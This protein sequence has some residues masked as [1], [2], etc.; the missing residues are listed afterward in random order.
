MKEGLLN[1]MR[2]SGVFASCR[3]THRRQAMILTYHRFGDQDHG[4]QISARA[5]E[6][7]LEYL[8]AHYSL[9][10][11]S[12]MAV[13]LAG[14][15]PLPSR[16]AAITIDDGYHDAYDIA[17]PLL[18]KYR[19]PA[20]VFVVSDFVEGQIWLWTD[21][22]RYFTARAARRQQAVAIE[23]RFLELDLSSAARREAAAEKINAVLKTLPEKARDAALH[24]LARELDVFL[25]E[26][27]PAEFSSICWKQARAMAAGGVEIGSHTVTHPI[28]TGLTDERLRRE[29]RHSKAHIEAELGRKVE[30][31]CYPN[32]DYD[33][34]VQS[35]AA[36]AGYLC[37][38]TTEDG[39]NDGQGSPLAL[40]RIHGEYD[41][42][43]FIQSTSGFE[44]IKNRWRRRL[45][46]QRSREAPK[47]MNDEAAGKT[48][49]RE[50]AAS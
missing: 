49:G 4:A 35:E 12:Q 19:A 45:R 25:P 39:L 13:R 40:R 37:A 48:A 31:F 16:M 27:P 44:Q 23:G 41:L 20:T 29:L 11:L 32:G 3:W 42:A 30:T 24:R 50:W 9:V 18:R 46:P 1:L 8:T 43:H 17:F 2:V 14:G 26:K 22:A 28:L 15:N 6:K 47:R 7:Q 33:S 21:K 38:A 5:F 10:P 36:R 34:R